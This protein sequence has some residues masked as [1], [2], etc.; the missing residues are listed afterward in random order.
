MI[1]KVEE[2]IKIEEKIKGYYTE[3][4]FIKESIIFFSWHG[5]LNWGFSTDL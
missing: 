2:N 3:L 1:N 5:K 4:E